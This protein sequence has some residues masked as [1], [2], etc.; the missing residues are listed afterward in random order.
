MD[1]LKAAVDAL[2]AAEGHSSTNQVRRG[3]IGAGMRGDKRRTYRFQDNSVVDHV[4]GK[5]ARCSDV[6]KGEF[7]RLW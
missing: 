5:Q 2:R 4:T 1:A 6:M 7:E 3:Q